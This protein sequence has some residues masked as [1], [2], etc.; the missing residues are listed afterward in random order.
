MGM[1]VLHWYPDFLHGGGVANAVRG[2]AAAESRQCSHVVI[3]AATPSQRPMYEPLDGSSEVEVLRWRPSRT[4]RIA[5]QC[6]RL[7]ARGEVAKLGAVRPDIVHVHG[8]FNLD[9]LWASRLFRCPIVISPH[10]ACHPVVLAKSRRAAKRIYL[11][12]ERLLLRHHISMFHALSPA[13]AEHLAAVFPN[14]PSYCAPQGPG[15]PVTEISP[16]RDTMQTTAGQ[17]V[18]FLFVG[19]LDVFTKGLDILLDAFEIVASRSGRAGMHLML[20][21]PDWKG[22]RTWL[23]HRAAQLGISDRVT[24]TGPLTGREVAAVLAAAD[25]YVQVSRHDGFPLSVAEA[26]LANKPAV[27]SSAIGTISY[28]EIASLPHIKVVPASRREAAMAM[29]ETAGSLPEVRS[30]ALCCQRV[31]TNFFSWDRIARLH[32]DQYLQL[33][34]A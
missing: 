33:L 7:M 14:A 10:G 22:G 17:K 11:A 31:V 18:N 6:L 13:E 26:L 4:L 12:A 25:I 5:G 1:R 24:L 2:F 20:A 19:R 9:N 8:E 32:V 27:L 23:E 3:A 15:V 16:R 21:G 30:A 28:P 34:H 29:M